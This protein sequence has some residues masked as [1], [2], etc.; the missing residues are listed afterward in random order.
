LSVRSIGP[1]DVR[2]KNKLVFATVGILV[3][4]G[5]LGTTSMSATT[6]FVTPT[7]L[8]E[9]NFEGE[10]VNLEG[11]VTDLRTEGQTVRFRVT[12][13]TTSVQVVYRGT[14]PETLQ[15]GRVVIAKGAVEDGTLRAKQ[16]SVRAHEGSDQ[17]PDRPG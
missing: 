1:D 8:D 17:R 4:V 6:Q 16:L 9:G 3:L 5:V 2:R 15:N 13:N 7:K 10:H 14:L 11:V 12:D